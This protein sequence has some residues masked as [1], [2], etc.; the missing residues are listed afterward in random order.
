MRLL[1][2]FSEEKAV[3]IYSP[4]NLISLLLSVGETNV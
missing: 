3:F 1:G 2:P 4:F